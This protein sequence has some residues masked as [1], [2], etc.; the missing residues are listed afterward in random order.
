MAARSK[1]SWPESSKLRE[2]QEACRFFDVSREAFSQWRAA[3][4]PVEKDGSFDL[5]KILRWRIKARGITTASEQQLK[6]EKL[7]IQNAAARLKLRQ[8]QGELVSRLAVRAAWSE[9]CHRIRARL[10][11]VPGE[12]SAVVPP[13]QRQEI[14]GEWRH[15]VRLILREMQEWSG[16]SSGDSGSSSDSESEKQPEPA[17]KPR[18]RS[19]A[20]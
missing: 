20:G 17:R 3:G 1:T 14:V 13:A 11:A 10:E 18:R 16:R 12:M 5:L 2:V 7:E 8:Q 9:L 6:C 19:R 15:K 4:M